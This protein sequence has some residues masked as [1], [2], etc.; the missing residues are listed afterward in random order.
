MAVHSETGNP[1]AALGGKVWPRRLHRQLL[2]LVPPAGVII[3]LDGD[4]WGQALDLANKFPLSVEVH[5]V[6]RFAPG[7]DPASVGRDKLR[8]LLCTE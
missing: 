8:E 4:A 3:A 2:D 1:V 5:D 7:E 6:L